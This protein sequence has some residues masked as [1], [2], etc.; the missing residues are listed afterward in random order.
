M[1]LVQCSGAEA[2]VLD[3]E[4]ADALMDYAF[5]VATYHRHDLVRL[6][7][8]DADHS[9]ITVTLLLGPGSELSTRTTDRF[10]PVGDELAAVELRR[11]TERL[12]VFTGAGLEESTLE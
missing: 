3:D 7:A 5:E 12:T 2:F 6:P 4:V 1:Q 10:E 9:R 8:R 11:R